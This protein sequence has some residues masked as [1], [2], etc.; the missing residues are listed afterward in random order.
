MNTQP[1]EHLKVLRHYYENEITSS[2]KQSTPLGLAI[3]YALT[4]LEQHLFAI[5]REAAYKKEMND[6]FKKICDI[7]ETVK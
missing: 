1:I 5:T 7:L 3:H 2:N 4:Y 6:Y